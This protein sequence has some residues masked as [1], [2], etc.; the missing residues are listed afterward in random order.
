MRRDYIFADNF[1]ID[2]YWWE[3]ARPDLEEEFELPEN[4]DVL[5]VGSGYAG[6]SAALELQRNGVET[7]VL[8][9]EALGWGA[10]SRNGG[11]VSGGVNIGKTS[12]LPA[13]MI[14]RMIDEAAA[15]YDHLERVIE[16]E[17]IDCFYTRCGRFVGAH[18]RSAY[19]ALERRADELNSVAE[20][21]AVMIPRDRQR[22]VLGSDYYHG[23]MTVDLSGA[24][25]PSLY[26]RGLL[27][28][29]R[30]AKVTLCPYTKAGRIESHNGKFL[31]ETT[32]GEIRASQVV[33]ATNGYTGDLTPWHQRR[34]VPVASYIIVTEEIGRERVRA[35]FP[36][37]RVVGDSKRVL[38]YFRPGP[39]H[40]RVLFGGRASFASKPAIETASRLYDFM[41]SVFPELRGV[42]VTHGWTGNVAF[43]YDRVPHFGTRSG[44]HYALGCNGSGVVMMGY[45]GHRV[46]LKI[47]GRANRLSVF[48]ALD[49]PDIPLYGGN[50]WFLP[51]L[52]G[53]YRFR[54][55]IDRTFTV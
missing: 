39:D 11:H 33:I 30:A 2:P 26:H 31:I 27:N 50:P 48:E 45:L 37:L 43:T 16:R 54:D 53:Y 6:L 29:C 5:I 22:E 47:L 3:A 44:I 42:R 17:E 32:R 9:T 7:C 24:L 55:W 14:R 51:L 52:G 18:C 19:R 49:L 20:S 34:V 25:H 41:C 13:E 23:G 21:G 38:Y 46:A 8:D 28:A 4:T 36:S 1:K 12:G 40:K 10:S 35:L 15:A